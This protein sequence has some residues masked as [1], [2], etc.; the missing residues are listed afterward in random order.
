MPFIL[1]GKVDF[2]L[3]CLEIHSQALA[4]GLIIFEVSRCANS[5][6]WEESKQTR[7]WGRLIPDI[8]LT[9]NET[10]TKFEKVWNESTY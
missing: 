5:L 8:L 6:V 2:R 3:I 9:V 10:K 4:A 7:E 1:V